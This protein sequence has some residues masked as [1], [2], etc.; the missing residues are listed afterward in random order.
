MRTPRQTQPQ[1]TA[2]HPGVLIIRAPTLLEEVEVLAKLSYPEVCR[3]GVSEAAALLLHRGEVKGHTPLVLCTWGADAV[4][5]AS[6]YCSSRKTEASC[7]GHCSLGFLV[8]LKQLCSRLQAADLDSQ[9]LEENK[10][11][12]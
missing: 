12:I 7:S 8:N 9:S 5:G 2:A 1:S 3:C 6:S 4:P 10:T 11:L